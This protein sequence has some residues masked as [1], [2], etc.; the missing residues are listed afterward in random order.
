MTSIETKIIKW[1]LKKESNENHIE[2]KLRLRL[3][4]N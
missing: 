4:S 2:H 1:N 3:N